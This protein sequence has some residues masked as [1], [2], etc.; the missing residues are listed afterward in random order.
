M[1][2][3]VENACIFLNLSFSTFLTSVLIWQDVNNVSYNEG[4]LWI[5]S[6][7]GL[8]RPFPGCIQSGWK[9][10]A[11]NST[12]NWKVCSLRSLMFSEWGICKKCCEV[13]DCSFVSVELLDLP[14]I[15]KSHSY[16][17]QIQTFLL[18]IQRFIVLLCSLLSLIRFTLLDEILI[19]IVRLL[20]RSCR[21][22]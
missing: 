16:W 21:E 1:W 11:S 20:P 9:M 7:C 3:K 13:K 5:A 2:W 6:E 4:L 17:W 8:S 10:Y 12:F 15:D 18:E 22:L 19:R 14:N